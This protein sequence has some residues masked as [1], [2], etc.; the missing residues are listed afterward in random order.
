VLAK[1]ALG[2][3]AG[4]ADD[5]VA[6]A[7]DAGG[8]VVVIGILAGEVPAEGG[9]EA[10]AVDVGGGLGGVEGEVH[11]AGRVVRHK[12]DDAE[13]GLGEAGA[14]ALDHVIFA[15]R[16]IGEGLGELADPRGA[17]GVVRTAAAGAGAVERDV[18]IRPAPD[19]DRGDEGAEGGEEALGDEPGAQAEAGEGA[20]RGDGDGVARGRGGGGRRDARGRGRVRGREVEEEGLGDA[21]H[22]ARGRLRPQPPPARAG[23]RCRGGTR[24]DG[25]TSYRRT[26]WRGRDRC[27]SGRQDR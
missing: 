12:T 21:G 13:R 9:D 23:S 10:L 8:D 1:S 26:P 2:V 24:A 4:D 19:G 16:R 22:E 5:H 27:R 11:G 6:Q 14:R 18:F 3:G 7:D 17:G 25:E 20:G 15:P